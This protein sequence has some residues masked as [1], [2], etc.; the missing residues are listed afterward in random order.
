MPLVPRYTTIYIEWLRSRRPGKDASSCD[1][2]VRRKIDPRPYASAQRPRFL[3]EASADRSLYIRV[4]K[5]RNAAGLY[6]Q[7]D[8]HRSNLYATRN[9]RSILRINSFCLFA[10]TPR[11][12]SLRPIVLARSD[13]Y[14]EF[15]RGYTCLGN[16]VAISIRFYPGNGCARFDQ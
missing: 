9:F 8:P 10:R 7:F 13:I 15:V 12:G 16:C 1:R 4:Y 14:F 11:L 6:K 2:R 3:R 5:R